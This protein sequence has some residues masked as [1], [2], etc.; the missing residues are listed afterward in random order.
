[1]YRSGRL[2]SK[3]LTTSCCWTS[4]SLTLRI[5]LRISRFD[6]YSAMYAIQQ[7]YWLYA[8]PCRLFRPSSRCLLLTASFVVITSGTCTLSWPGFAPS[9]RRFLVTA[10]SAVSQL[11]L[12]CYPGPC[13]VACLSQYL[14]QSTQPVRIASAGCIC[15]PLCCMP[16]IARFAVSGHGVHS[17]CTLCYSIAC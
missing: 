9:S 6:M 1:M 16:V 10:S 7:G 14:S 3:A 11:A 17:T 15:P 4:A 2:R 8:Y 12:A 5:A 13:C